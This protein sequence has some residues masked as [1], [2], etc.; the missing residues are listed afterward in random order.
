MCFD[1]H[2]SKPSRRRWAACSGSSPSKAR[3]SMLT[4]TI[5]SRRR[6]KQMTQTHG[7]NG[8]TSVQLLERGVLLPSSV[9]K[10][11]CAHTQGLALPQAWNAGD[12]SPPG[13]S[14][15]SDS[16]AAPPVLSAHAVVTATKHEVSS[17]L[18]L[19]VRTPCGWN[20]KQS[21]DGGGGRHTTG[22]IQKNTLTVCMS[23][24]KREQQRLSRG[25]PQAR[26]GKRQSKL[27]ETMSHQ[28]K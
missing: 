19:L 26:K 5:L 6:C 27:K 18:L 8:I 25:K 17:P 12:V 2:E 11:M 15:R 20:T 22:G 13:R 14:R 9:R 28:W 16:R 1:S 7:I 24:V 4:Q 23:L 21:Q 10:H 3:T